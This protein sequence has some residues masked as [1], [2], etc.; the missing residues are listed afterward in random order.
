VSPNRYVHSRDANHNEVVAAFEEVFCSVFDAAPMGFGFPD[1]V[2][3][4][5]GITLLV[6]VKTEHGRLE[7]SQERFIRDWRGGKVHIV[8]SRDQAIDLAQ[9]TRSKQAGVPKNQGK[10]P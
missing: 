8:R 7:K 6:E 2:V 9:A 4:C 10:H 3:G 5:A 1:L